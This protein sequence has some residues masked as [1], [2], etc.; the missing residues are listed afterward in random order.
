[1]RVLPLEED[2]A[3]M[4]V[5]ATTEELLSGAASVNLRSLSRETGME[6]VL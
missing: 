1:M 4:S 5:S 2:V 3:R 6:N